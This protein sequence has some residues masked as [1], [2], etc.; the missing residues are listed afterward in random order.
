MER[1]GADLLTSLP[2]SPTF[3][4]P[5][6]LPRALA[7]DQAHRPTQTCMNAKGSQSFLGKEEKH[8]KTG[9][10][11]KKLVLKDFKLIKDHKDICMDSGNILD[12]AQIKTFGTDPY[13]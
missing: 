11:F 13:S 9:D 10:F 12:E 8:C 3:S 6:L 5:T 2:S 4:N 7:S 1:K